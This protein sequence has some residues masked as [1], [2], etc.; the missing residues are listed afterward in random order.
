[1]EGAYR[2]NVWTKARRSVAPAVALAHL[3]SQVI[4]F[5]FG[6]PSRIEDAWPKSPPFNYTDASYSGSLLFPLALFGLWRSRWRGKWLVLALGIGGLLIGIELAP[7][8][9]WVARLPLF[10]LALN[11]RLIFGFAFAVPALAALGLF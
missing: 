4:P 9:D 11:A 7:F 2:E 8:A 10:R 5:R 1:M 6:D 3:E